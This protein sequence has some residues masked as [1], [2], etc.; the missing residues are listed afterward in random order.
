MACVPERVVPSRCVANLG[1][2]KGAVVRLEDLDG[3]IIRVLLG[4]RSARHNAGELLPL[5][6]VIASLSLSWDSAVGMC[7]LEIE[8][9]LLCVSHDRQLVGGDC[10]ACRLTALQR[11]FGAADTG[12]HC[13]VGPRM[14][15]GGSTGRGTSPSVCRLGIR[16]GRRHRAGRPPCCWPAHR[17]QS[18]PFR[19]SR[20]L[21]EYL[22]HVHQ[23]ILCRGRHA[24]P[25]TQNRAPT[26]YVRKQRQ[27]ARSAADRSPWP[28]IPLPDGADL[29]GVTLR[30]AWAPV[31]VCWRP[32]R[33]GG[34]RRASKSEART[35]SADARPALAGDRVA[36]ENDRR[37]ASDKRAVFD[38]AEPAVSLAMCA[39][40]GGRF[41]RGRA[42]NRAPWAAARSG[43]CCVMDLA[44]GAWIRLRA[45]LT[46]G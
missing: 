45:D 28:A 19:T 9:W 21:R 11:S 27:T 29:A 5:S 20:H 14:W 4:G 6:R 43:R 12:L 39:T 18:R 38:V 37:E 33:D 36:G 32:V 40:V 23:Q 34:G 10:A 17:R 44:S 22:C 42:A 30:W 26:F 31:G 46:V 2:L 1:G 3:R 35:T 13:A 25:S 7:R 16:H 8:R 24:T 41:A 15:T